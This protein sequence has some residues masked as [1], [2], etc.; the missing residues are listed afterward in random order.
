MSD[1]CIKYEL[2]LFSESPP[3]VKS[4]LPEGG[5]VVY[6]RYKLFF[7][8]HTLPIHTDKG[9][10]YIYN[11]C[12]HI[13]FVIKLSLTLISKKDVLNESILITKDNETENAKG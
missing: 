6:T 1:R 11:V 10:N 8:C 13:L 2:V 4:S 5:L 12:M 9:N 3:T 7:L